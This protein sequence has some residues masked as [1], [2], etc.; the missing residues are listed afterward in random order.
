MSS[1][2]PSFIFPLI[3]FA[4]S[5]CATSSPDIEE[6]SYNRAAM[7]ASRAPLIVRSADDPQIRLRDTPEVRAQLR[8]YTSIRRPFVVDG[9]NNR[10]RYLAMIHRILREYDLPDDLSN[11][12]FIE[13]RFIP[14]ARS[15]SG[16]VGMW[17]FMKR[18]ARKF[19]LEVGIWTDERKDPEKATRAA[20]RYLKKLHGQFDNWLLALASYNA[21]PG[22][23]RRSIKACGTTDFFELKECGYV[24]KETQDFVARFIAITMI[25]NHL[26]VYGFEE[27]QRAED[28]GGEGEFDD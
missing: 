10:K 21:G 27:E 9:L 17:Q 4:F 8:Y 13:S 24:K 18:T 20:A 7:S 25:T 1:K 26:D 14:D 15:G 5:A 3:L 16:A 11:V 12:A 19:G 2:I 23:I 6:S 22:T 28:L